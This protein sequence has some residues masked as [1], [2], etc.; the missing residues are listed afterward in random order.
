MTVKSRAVAVVSLVSITITTPSALQTKRPASLLLDRTYMNDVRARG[1]KGDAA[2]RAA[3][4]ALEEDAKKALAIKPV[5]VMDKTITPPSGDNHDY[6]SQ[7]P[8]GGRTFS[9]DFDEWVP[10][11]ATASL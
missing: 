7:A 4:A 10:I 6:M 9:R 5:S 11:I 3:I 1:E 8:I 2:I